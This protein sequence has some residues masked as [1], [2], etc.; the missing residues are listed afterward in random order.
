MSFQANNYT[1]SIVLLMVLTA[2]IIMIRMRS[3]FESNWPL[4]YWLFLTFLSIRYPEDTYEPRIILVGL[5]MGL[6][7]RFE[8][9]NMTFGRIFMFVECCIWIY[10]LYTSFILITI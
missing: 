1:L 7:L 4:L 6:L 5:G 2:A 3:Q 8:F 10:I 9:I